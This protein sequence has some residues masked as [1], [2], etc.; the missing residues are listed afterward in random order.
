MEQWIIQGI[1]RMFDEF[2]V[3][4]DV[5]YDSFEEAA[6]HCRISEAPLRLTRLVQLTLLKD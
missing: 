1:D 2:Y 6:K 4:D 3:K 5:V